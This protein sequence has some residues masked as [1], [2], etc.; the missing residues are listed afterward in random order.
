MFDLVGMMNQHKH[1]VITETQVG[2]HEAN[3]N[4]KIAKAICP[5][6]ST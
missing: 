4:N 1:Q 3:M 2:L 5:R 6:K